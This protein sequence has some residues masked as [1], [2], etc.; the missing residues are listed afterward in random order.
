MNRLLQFG[1]CLMLLAAAATVAGCGKFGGPPAGPPPFQP[2][3]VEVALPTSA[4][5]TDYEDFSGTTEATRT[6]D[7]R[8]RVTG[9]LRAVHFKHGAVVKKGEPLFEIEP[10]HYAA[11]VDRAT[12]VVAE[13]EAHLKRL[14]LDHERARKLHPT[15]TITKEQFDLITGNV[16]EAEA[17]LQAA[18]AS[19]KMANTNLGYCQIAAPFDGRMSRPNIDPGNLV[20]ADDTML[21]RIVTQDPIWVY[22]D[23]D[24]RT[25]LRLRRLA[26]YAGMGGD[27][28]APIP[29][30]MGLS[31]EKG[32]PHVGKLDF[33]DNRLDPATGTLKIRAVF[34]NED[35]LL[36]PGLFVRVRLQIG[37]PHPALLVP[38]SAIGTDQ[39]QK[40]LYV[41]DA[42][43]EVVYRKVE[44]GKQ[45]EGMRM[46]AGNLNPD[47]RVVV[48]GLQ[49]A[50]PGTKVVPKMAGTAQTAEAPS[51][52]PS[53]LTK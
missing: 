44:V 26:P 22:F 48:L 9:Y 45:Y 52:K 15:G 35:R 4:E 37:K 10:T 29:V 18:K 50:R 31:D 47:E 43:D 34:D 1:R 23:L 2:L 36:S 5:I 8:A 33:E 24:E 7:I 51:A 17:T 25:M 38:E 28:E 30:L 40:F 20:K 21:S 13:A 46:I 41:V 53:P 16:A 3:A 12:G 42:K 27:D 19:L 32:Y 14:N 6:I 49:R 11:E 39:G